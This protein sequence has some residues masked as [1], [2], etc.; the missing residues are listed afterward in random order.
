MHMTPITRHEHY[1][2]MR[3]LA[4]SDGAPHFTVLDCLF[5]AYGP[6]H[7]RRRRAW[8]RQTTRTFTWGVFDGIEV[9]IEAP[10]LPERP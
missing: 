2:E 1:L 9:I 5:I 4:N 8:E 10:R 3:G 7:G 6:G